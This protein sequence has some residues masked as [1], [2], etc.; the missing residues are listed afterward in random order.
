MARKRGIF[1]W[2]PVRALM[3]EAGAEIVAREAVDVLLNFLEAR[4]RNITENA[5]VFAKHSRR[6]KV[7]KADVALA[8]DNI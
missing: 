7:S 2:S 8:I 6:K 1:A 5:L 4:A 3:Q